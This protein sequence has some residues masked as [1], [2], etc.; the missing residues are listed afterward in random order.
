[1]PGTYLA[2]VVLAFF[3]FFFARVADVFFAGVLATF[4]LAAFF[5]VFFAGF[6]FPA[7]F[8]AVFFLAPFVAAAF[9]ADFL[10]DLLAAFFLAG[11]LTRA[12][13]EDLSG[14]SVMLQL[15][16]SSVP[17][18]IEIAPNDHWFLTATEN[19]IY[20]SD[21]QTGVVLRRLFARTPGRLTRVV[22]SKD[23]SAVFAKHVLNDGAEEILGWSSETGLPFAH[24]ETAA[25]APDAPDWNWIEK[26]WP[27]SNVAPYDGDAPKKYLVDQKIDRLVDV[28]RVERVEPTNHG[29]VVQVTIAG[30]SK[31]LEEPFAAYGYYFID[32]VQKK[33]LV[34]VSAKT[35]RT[36]CGQPHGAFAFDGRYLVI[37]PTELD[38]SSSFIN[39]VVVDTRAKPP[40]VK[41]SRDCQD[42]QVS[43]MGMQRG[44]IVVRASPHQATIWDQLA[45]AQARERCGQED[46][47]IGLGPGGADERPDLLGREHLDVAAAA[48]PE[49]IDVRDRIPRNSDRG[50]RA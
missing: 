15:G 48:H 42:F 26:E 50:G 14:F 29:N 32:V 25:P 10:A 8:F 21:L 37:A 45:A 38:A 5:V 9:L 35:L 33:I 49:P 16:A 46:C 1:M 20:L 31:D 27:A 40:V 7:F 44:L 4:F 12:A 43:G 3:F 6:F 34:D 19:A 36:F 23:G 47:R 22:I 28:N 13:P 24:A 39:S 30:E 41:W 18:A 11:P 2:L 17:W